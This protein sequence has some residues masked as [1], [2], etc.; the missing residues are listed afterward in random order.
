MNLQIIASKTNLDF[1][2]LLIDQ[3]KREQNRL[4][5]SHQDLL[6]IP[7]ISLLTL[8]TKHLGIIKLLLNI[9]ISGKKITTGSKDHSTQKRNSILNKLRRKEQTRRSFRNP[10][11]PFEAPSNI[12]LHRVPVGARLFRFRRAWQGASHEGIIKKGLSWSWKKDPP[13]L[14][15]IH[16][17]HNSSL[18]QLVAQLKRKRVMYTG[19]SKSSSRKM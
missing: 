12:E 15:R 8:G 10:R 11:V 14:K 2:I 7:T 18:D 17:K 6:I 13:L 4:E 1:V 3:I 5:R 19:C 16:Q 9:I